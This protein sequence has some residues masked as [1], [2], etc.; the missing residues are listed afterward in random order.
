VW[1]LKPLGDT[2]DVA[3]G[4]GEPPGETDVLPEGQFGQETQR[5]G[6]HRHPIPGIGVIYTPG[7]RARVGLLPTGEDVQQGGLARP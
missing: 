6:D 2:V 3:R 5:L 1:D 7:H 4:L